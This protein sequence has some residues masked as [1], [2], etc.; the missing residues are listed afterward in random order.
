MREE[1]RPNEREGELMGQEKPRFIT[2]ALR[3]LS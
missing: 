2:L 3:E 1:E